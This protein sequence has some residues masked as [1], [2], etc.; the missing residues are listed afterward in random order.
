MAL[1][2]DIFA[3]Q[4]CIIVRIH[5]PYEKRLNSPCIQ[6]ERTRESRDSS[7]IPETWN[8][9]WEHLVESQPASGNNMALI[10][11]HF[12]RGI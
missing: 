2:I 5:T 8:G 1:A 10:K 9:L 6:D 7:R 12:I 11:N 4:L 3:I